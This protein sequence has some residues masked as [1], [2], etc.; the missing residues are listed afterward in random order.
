MIDGGLITEMAKR[1][2]KLL[3]HF[4]LNSLKA[5]ESTNVVLSFFRLLKDVQQIAQFASLPSH[6]KDCTSRRTTNPYPPVPRFYSP[7][8]MCFTPHVW[9][10]LKSSQ[11][12]NIPCVPYVDQCIRR[13]LCNC[14]DGLHSR[15]TAKEVCQLM[16]QFW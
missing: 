10:R 12:M 3:S 2:N 9:K 11:W 13:R 16:C 8:R 15:E 6:T 14:N 1:K 7:A 4:C 5:S